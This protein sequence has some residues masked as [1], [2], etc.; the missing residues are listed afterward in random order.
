M[1]AQVVQQLVK[2]Q[3]DRKRLKAAKYLDVQWSR[4]SHLST[5]NMKHLLVAAS[6]M[7]GFAFFLAFSGK[8]LQVGQE[9]HFGSQGII[10]QLFT[11]KS[12]R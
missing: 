8:S 4:W 5:K 3:T 9:K 11:H 2:K 6:E 1:A 7:W 10:S 12:I